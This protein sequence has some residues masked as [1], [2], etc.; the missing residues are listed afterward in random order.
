M[1][2]GFWK[3][4]INRW[5]ELDSCLQCALYCDVVS[6]LLF[7][8]QRVIIDCAQGHCWLSGQETSKQ[9]IQTLEAITHFSTR[10]PRRKGKAFFVEVSEVRKTFRQFLTAWEEFI[11]NNRFAG[12][13]DLTEPRRLFDSSS[14]ARRLLVERRKSDHWS[15]QV[16]TV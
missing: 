16:C 14:I 9:S 4:G 5:K 7:D 6:L 8:A 11:R 3:F 2:L 13:L 15:P 12:M 1:V 10:L